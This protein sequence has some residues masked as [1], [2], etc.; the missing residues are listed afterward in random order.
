MASNLYEETPQEINLV[1]K[2]HP[3]SFIKCTPTLEKG[4]IP[5]P[6][7]YGNPSTT[8]SNQA[9]SYSTHQNSS[10][11]NLSLASYFGK[12]QLCLNKLPLHCLNSSISHLELQNKNNPILLS[13][14][15]FMFLNPKLGLH[16]NQ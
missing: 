3:D 2:P 4:N 7:V 14:Q 1:P 10:T 15:I 11:S 8:V 12:L 16:K 9:P 6:D 5:L 13:F